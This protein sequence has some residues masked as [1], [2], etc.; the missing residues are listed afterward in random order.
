MENISTMCYK[1][2][3]EMET[4]NQK[5]NEMIMAPKFAKLLNESVDQ[6]DLVIHKSETNKLVSEFVNKSIDNTS[7]VLNAITEQLNSIKANNRLIMACEMK[8]K[9]LSKDD[10][11]NL[12]LK[13]LSNNIISESTVQMSLTKDIK[14]I[15]KKL[16]RFLESSYSTKE[17][18]LNAMKSFR[19][20]VS[21]CTSRLNKIDV[22]LLSETDIDIDKISEALALYKNTESDMQVNES[23]FVDLNETDKYKN[24]INSN[25]LIRIREAVHLGTEYLMRANSIMDKIMMISHE[26]NEKILSEFVLCEVSEK[27]EIQFESAMANII[28]QNSLEDDDYDD[29]IK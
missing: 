7:K 27:S 21:E 20:A 5:I 19:N 22:S 3:I 18:Y 23:V 8:M 9:F 2:L 16:T 1:Y 15:N 29:F 17:E 6:D 10:R 26:N 11:E 28:Y 14:D 12:K 24:T 13:S 4:E 25:N